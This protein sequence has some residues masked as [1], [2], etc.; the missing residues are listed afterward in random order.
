LKKTDVDGYFRLVQLGRL[1]I[2]VDIERKWQIFRGYPQTYKEAKG[3]FQSIPDEKRTLLFILASRVVVMFPSDASK[4][5][6]LRSLEFLLGDL[7]E[8]WKEE[9]PKST[10]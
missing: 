8:R 10:E 3:M 7:K 1:N 6:V 9:D 5:E 2:P 4:S